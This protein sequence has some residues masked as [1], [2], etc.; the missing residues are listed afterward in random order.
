MTEAED[1][2]L[3][4][5]ALASYN[6]LGPC[7]SWAPHGGDETALKQDIPVRIETGHHP[8]WNGKR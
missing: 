6:T 4:V 3:F 5:A 8:F 2:V 7:A 1:D